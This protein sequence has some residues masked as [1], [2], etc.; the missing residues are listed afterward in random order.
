MIRWINRLM[1][2]SRMEDDVR[3]EMEF[4][5]QARAEDL[6]RRHGLTRE[7]AARRARMEFGSVV[8]YREEARAAFG[9]RFADECRADLRF[10]A[11]T[12]R[13]SSG[14]ALASIGILALAIGANAAFFT[15]YSNYALKPLPIRAVERHVSVEGRDKQGN[16]APSWSPQEIARLREAGRDQ[17]EDLYAMSGVFQILV[18]APSQRNGMTMA[19]SHDFFAALG[20]KPAEGRVFTEAEEREP[21]AV[22]SDSGWKRMFPDGRSPLGRQF[23]VRSTWFTVVGVM[24]ASFVGTAAA[25]PDFWTP[26]GVKRYMREDMGE[27]MEVSG[28]LRPGVSKERAVAVLTA[29]ATRFERPEVDV[30]ASIRVR[31]HDTYLASEADDLGPTSVILFGIFL[32][33]LLIACANLANLFVART[34]ARSHEI[35]M[36]FSLGAG[37]WRIIRQLLTES[38]MLALMG[39]AVGLWLAALGIEHAHLWLFSIA[40][41]AGAMI[42][43]VTLDWRVFVYSGVLGLIAGAGFGLLPAWNATEFRKRRHGR[44]RKVLLGGQVAA[45][46]VLLMLAAVLVRHAQ[47]MNVTNAGFDTRRVFDLQLEPPVPQVIERLRMHPGVAGVA[48]VQRVPFYE[49]GPRNPVRAGSTVAQLAHSYVDEHYFEMLGIP[50]LKGR[51]F[52]RAETAVKGAARVAVIS[53]AGARRLWPGGRAVGESMTIGA[54]RIEDKRVEGVYQVIGI[55]PDTLQGSPLVAPDPGVVYLPAS[56]GQDVIGAVMIR[57]HDPQP[58]VLAAVREICASVQGATGCDP[59][60]VEQIGVIQRFP[61]QAAASITGL[62]GSVALLLTAVGLYSVVSHLVEQRR[63]EIG[64]LV[65]I[66]ATPAQVTRRVVGEAVVCFGAGLAVGLPFC[67]GLSAL[68]ASSVVGIQSFDAVAYAGV[69]M[70]LACIGGLACLVPVRRALRLEPMVVLRQD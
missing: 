33:V 48:G 21:V 43:P 52:H 47:R 34:A 60:S 28:H 25:V 65:A 68:A 56:V 31:P 46:F 58:A 6:E 20:A 3:A 29:V 44:L 49:R 22:L 11:R 36:R 8:H 9:F 54:A 70:L 63:R 4:H 67:V 26:S 19:V 53:A 12:L 40:A 23:R 66:G 35:M 64:I 62:L 57:L 14:Y 10:A 5:Q 18:L 69:P 30:V 55:V 45:S 39:A 51:G 42:L 2:R 32:L 38:T 1:Y 37:R 61:L 15:L 17:F 24:P 59:K 41:D 13:K 27:R 7:E 16:G 50:V